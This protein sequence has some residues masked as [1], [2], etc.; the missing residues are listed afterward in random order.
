MKR[1]IRKGM[2]MVLVVTML[3]TQAGFSTSAFTKE[4]L[5][6]S[7]VR[8]A[9]TTQDLIIAK[10]DVQMEIS[11]N[12]STTL[13]ITKNTTI[14]MKGNATFSVSSGNAITVSNGVTLTIILNGF[15][16][17]VKTS[18]ESMAG[19]LLPRNA[20]LIVREGSAING[21]FNVR[22]GPG[23]VPSAGT[24]GVDSYRNG[25]AEIYSGYG[26]YGG[27]GGNAPGAGIG[28]NGG[29]GGSVNTSYGHRKVAYGGGVYTA[30]EN[31]G[32]G[33][34]GSA[35]SSPYC[36][37]VYIFG[38]ITLN[39]NGG[40]H[41]TTS[42]STALG[43]NDHNS[44]GPQGNGGGAG[45]NGGSAHGAAGIGGGG[46]GGGS[47]GAGGGGSVYWEPGASGYPFLESAG[48]GGGGGGQTGGAG[49]QGSS[50]KF[51]RRN[52][53]SGRAH[54]GG[55]GGIGENNRNGAGS[56]GRGGAS[57]SVITQG[58][59]GYLYHDTNTTTTINNSK[60]STSNSETN[61]RLTNKMIL[62]SE[63]IIEVDDSNI[64]YDGKAKRP[65]IKLKDKNGKDITSTL[66]TNYKLA[67]K[68]NI[69][70]GE[71]TG[72]ITISSNGSVTDENYLLVDGGSY[73]IKFTIK[74]NEEP[75][76][77]KKAD[78]T[79]SYTYGNSFQASVDKHTENKG[80]V[81]W[82]SVIDSEYKA[83]IASATGVSTA[84]I[85]TK[86]GKMKLRVTITQDTKN[87]NGVY[88][89]PETMT[90][91]F[92]TDIQI[93]PKNIDGGDIAVP[94][95]GPYTYAGGQIKPTYSSSSYKSGTI[96]FNTNK[97]SAHKILEEGVDFELEYGE[98]TNVA[99]GG[100]VIIK[101]IG[102][103][104]GYKDPI[105]FTITARDINDPSVTTSADS[106]AY[107]GNSLTV[108][109]VV[110]ITDA[111]MGTE[112]T[113]PKSD[114]ELSWAS[115]K[116]DN[117]FT[118]LD[119]INVGEK[120]ITIT[121]SGNITNT[122]TQKYEIVQADI[123]TIDLGIQR[124][125]D[126]YF[127]GKEIESRPTIK[128]YDYALSEKG[129][130][131]V[132][133]DV[134][135]PNPDDYEIAFTNH[136]EA[137]PTTTTLTGIN[138]F[139]GT[140]TLSGS[141][142][143]GYDVLK[144]PLY[145]LPDTEQWK[146]YGTKDIF[147]I[148]QNVNEPTYRVF[149]R[150]L[151]AS[152]TEEKK[153]ADLT[154]DEVNRHYH[155]DNLPITGYPMEL[156]GN[157][158]RVGADNPLL[159]KRDT[160]YKFTISDL[161]LTD[162]TKDNYQVKLVDNESTYRVKS[163]LYSGTPAEIEGIE[164]KND[165]YIQKPVEF[166]APVDYTISKSDVLDTSVNNW[167]QGI[168]FADG[169]YSKDGMTYFLRYHNPDN[170]NDPTNGAISNG[171]IHK[172]KQ[173]IVLPT[174]TLTITSDAWTAFN[175][176]ADFNYFLNR[177]AIGLI[178]A[179]DD[180]SKVNTKHYYISNKKLG[181]AELDKMKV[182]KKG[183]GSQ[184]PI[185]GTQE[186][187]WIEQDQFQLQIDEYNT[188]RKYIYVRVE[189]G[190]GNVSYLNS[191]GIV[192]DKDAPILKAEYKQNAAWTISE[193]VKITG[194]V[195]D[196]NAGLKE[197]YVAYQIDGGALQVVKDIEANGRFEINN[198]PDGNYTL[199]L[200]AW[201]K[202]DNQAA[203]IAFHVMKDTQRPRILLQADTTTIAPQQAITFD[204]KVGASKV[205]KVEVSY[206]GGEWT[207][208]SDGVQ[209]PYIV[210]EN[211]VYTFRITNGAGVVSKES[212]IEFTKID[213]NVPNIKI[214][215]QDLAG[216][217][218]EDKRFTNSDVQVMFSNVEKNLGDSLFE[219]SIDDGT[220]WK[221]V[222][223]NLDNE[224]NAKLL[225]DE[226]SYV[227][228]FRVTAKNGYKDEKE[229]HVGIDRTKPKMNITVN[230]A[231]S[232][233]I[234]SIIDIFRAKRQ[235]V[236]ANEV[237]EG[238]LASGVSTV[239]YYIVE[240]KETQ[241]SLPSEDK[242]IEKMVK[243]RWVTGKECEVEVGSDYVVYFKVKD[244]AGNIKY[245]RSDR[246]VID[247]AAPEIEV[248][249]EQEGKWDKDP[250][251]DVYVYDA[252]PGVDTVTYQVDGTTIDASESFT[253][254]NLSLTTG[255][256]TIHISA[257]D[258]SGNISTKDVKVKVDTG[259]PTITANAKT[260]TV[261]N[262]PIEV[263]AS[264][265]G[266]SKLDKIL[267]AKNGQEFEDISDIIKR[268]GQYL[269][270][271]N[272]DYVFRA[273]TGAGAYTETTVYI[274]EFSAIES[275]IEALVSA[276]LA[277]GDAYQDAS[278]TNQDVTVMFSN[279]KANLKG[280]SYQL[281]INDGSW[282]PVN[283]TNGYVTI[284]VSSEGSHR[285]EFKVIYNT[286][287]KASEPVGINVKID[288]TLPE[289]KMKIKDVE[290]TGDTLIEHG[291]LYDNYFKAQEYAI[292]EAKDTLSGVEHKEIFA[293][294]EA[295]I[296]SSIKGQT[297][298]SKIEEIGK[299][300]WLEG[301]SI[302]LNP[303][304]KYVVFGK[305]YDEAGNVTYVSSDGVVFDDVNPTLTSD[306]NQN[307]WYKDDRTDIHFS[308]DDTLSEVKTATYKIN[309]GTAVNPTLSYGEF[310]ISTNDLR[311]GENTIDI[312]VIDHAGNEET[313]K[314]LAK[315]DTESPSI[316]VID[317]IG[318]SK[319][320]TKNL[321]EVQ[322]SAG[323]SG[324]TKVEVKK[325]DAGG[326][327][328]ITTSYAS[329]YLAQEK[330]VYWF[331]VV[332]GANNSATTSINLNNI[333][334]DIPIVTYIMMY[335]DG[336][337][338]FEGNWSKNE[339]QVQFT[340]ENGNQTVE[341]YL[342]KTDD[343]A[344]TEVTA[345]KDGSA[346]FKSIEG[347][348]NYTMKLV[349]DN[350]LESEEISVNIKVDAIAPKIKINSDLNQ[351]VKETQEL[352]V[353]V[354][355]DESGVDAQGYSFDN[356]YTWQSESKTK[357]SANKIVGLKA[358]DAVS[359][360]TSEKAIVE[361]I[362]SQ[363]PTVTSFQQKG[364]Q[365]AK[366]RALEASI[367]DYCDLTSRSGSGIAEVYAMTSYPYK[368]GIENPNPD[369]TFEM[370][371]KD[372]K[373]VTKKELSVP[374]DGTN[375]VWLVTED[376]VGNQKIYS[377]EV[378]NMIGS[379]DDEGNTDKPKP[380][381]PTYPEE[382]MKPN[383]PQ[384]PEDEGTQ[385]KPGGSESNTGTTTES[386]KETTSGTKVETRKNGKKEEGKKTGGNRVAAKET[387]GSKKTADELTN[388]E[389]DT[390]K[391]KDIQKIA[392][393]SHKGT[394][395]QRIVYM[396][397]WILLV[398]VVIWMLYLLLRY[399]R[400]KNRLINDIEEQQKE[401]EEV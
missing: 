113:L 366:E 332:N 280:L 301:S 55:D 236:K 143:G 223:E 122:R 208:I 309:G 336:N 66:N 278:W 334:K 401:S 383:P 227:I 15:T 130:T 303:N 131:T 151:N 86:V 246:I 166:K 297:T 58:S 90:A 80:V 217:K 146:Y 308:T 316:R 136:K 314:Y 101:G 74:P 389:E 23:G 124:A 30:G 84:I 37:N 378:T 29:S 117:T 291:F 307:E 160:T 322:A 229:F 21:T 85:P 346:I 62:L 386:S 158:S 344:Y 388:V 212:S 321:L 135:V 5:H 46:V 7:T 394:T 27:A 11:S 49:G 43:G 110:K 106:P 348:H 12:R 149:T 39:V 92:D 214:E 9:E 72:I 399:R 313:M 57:P 134:D 353:E 191:D 324:I 230:D 288:K 198:L 38:R 285:Y 311:N 119:I 210:K 169:D 273:V 108:E 222:S 107:T 328:D 250:S 350:G 271:E 363:G 390:Q 196:E 81:S 71:K 276:K 244:K 360:I 287:G 1:V 355:D 69:D 364:T 18:A 349:L 398:M 358:K 59:L 14:I 170:A 159:D 351:W 251:M 184:N 379:G 31:G 120:Q 199:T 182:P 252:N 104:D 238:S 299:N 269:A 326:W 20:T 225:L 224:A 41:N 78:T 338:Y 372:G 300:R 375:S 63:C 211:G 65:D 121:G 373:W 45:G 50:P 190:A 240:G 382:P 357:V 152:A 260:P 268:E 315:K 76:S 194:N 387:K 274:D 204:A 216:N 189:D 105:P 235:V 335:D 352:E 302:A 294:K 259:S 282:Q 237:D 163:Y 381:D 2:S 343:G 100:T 109:P 172:F 35:A 318:S 127:D 168:N 367:D 293:I 139:K 385:G 203:P 88:N 162:A 207:H 183:A 26:G 54:Q 254:A 164:G 305:V 380:G 209:V 377:I 245:G 327:E 40:Q 258:K 16:L 138:N 95:I 155:K 289:A 255:D 61:K 370:E 132:D 397:P 154:E 226:G 265:T 205:A 279:R 33:Y 140:K 298:A 126:V 263:D 272:G 17:D 248:S 320:V 243:E 153:N 201:D 275:D 133:P 60:N 239:E 187:A 354:E 304:D 177:D 392:T 200:S 173:D 94:S 147:G 8:A 51:S 36:G 376:N 186:E 339:V 213:T 317:S 341:K 25:N 10:G 6:T 180:M 129:T 286:T 292:I 361:K 44:G 330:G 161:K 28:G 249:Y 242:A 142:N 67:Y 400:L 98:N 52:G 323:Q 115:R 56:G 197:R 32:N 175:A 48:G 264:Y 141:T 266:P 19:I 257:S 262:V 118:G 87:V 123:G 374:Y 77:I 89:F 396:I 34:D 73:D 13:S 171:I 167:Y 179:K 96:E 261:V 53:D 221:E 253:I 128:Y 345:E 347:S 82:D 365:K 342:Y 296:P 79:Y 185:E 391:I 70:A 111:N 312:S 42:L 329:G 371:Q 64:I 331:R 47:G 233:F 362:D 295:D 384:N 270:Q 116:K 356:G 220:T 395:K 340:N 306:I 333:S 144:R 206:N 22:G 114:Y 234:R 325:P 165:W 93:N 219:Y 290:W 215:V 281:K 99:D 102:N 192:F 337:E 393:T 359:N 319:L 241:K 145:I 4:V 24:E 91:T 103:Y 231:P 150:T 267:L 181:K 277:N 156:V 256:H 97:D 202:A 68:N 368:D 176:N 218:I 3:F 112:Y 83:E 137:G 178:Y 193:D 195:Y 228:Q 369:K 174:G 148:D 157:L 247:A 310:T 284:P 188:K 232:S 75:I 125:K 283:A